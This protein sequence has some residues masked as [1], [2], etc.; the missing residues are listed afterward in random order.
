MNPNIQNVILEIMKAI[1]NHHQGTMKVDAHYSSG[2][3]VL[4][5]PTGY[6]LEPR[7]VLASV[8]EQQLHIMSMTGVNIN[9]N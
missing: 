1:F 4:I 7:F 9:F 5:V 3:G 8:S 6:P 2:Q